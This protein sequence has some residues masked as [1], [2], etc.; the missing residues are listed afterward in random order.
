M[1]CSPGNLLSWL[2]LPPAD[3]PGEASR[4][5]GWCWVGLHCHIAAAPSCPLPHVV[6]LT[7][8][9]WQHQGSGRA[10]H[11]RPWQGPR[12]CG[13]S[14]SH[15]G[16]PSAPSLGAAALQGPLEGLGIR[17]LPKGIRVPVLAWAFSSLTSTFTSNP[18]LFPGS[19]PISQ[20]SIPELAADEVPGDKEH[21]V[22]P[23]GF[24]RALLP[25]FEQRGCLQGLFPH[26]HP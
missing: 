13:Q 5:T 14:G 9:Q 8:F 20:L 2:E 24:S 22:P 7:A 11:G 3:M 23:Q 21:A 10:G 25:P 19:F 1:P 4:S 15:P 16:H 17:P 12:G 18:L 6:F 26:S